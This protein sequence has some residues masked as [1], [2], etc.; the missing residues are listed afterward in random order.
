MTDFVA[1]IADLGSNKYE[2]VKCN[3]E[4]LKNL[5]KIHSIA[6]GELLLEI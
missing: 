1:S 4:K 6:L 3:C 5:K 2:P